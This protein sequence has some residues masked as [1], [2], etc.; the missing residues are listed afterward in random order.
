MQ[1]LE[2]AKIVNTHGLLGEVKVL[3]NY[4]G[5]HFKNWVPK[6]V[7]YLKNNSD[8]QPLTIIK[9]RTHKNFL[10]VTFEDYYKIDLVL[11]MKNKSLGIFDESVATDSESN[12]S[13]VNLI[14]YQ[15]INS[16]SNQ[17]LGTVT[18]LIENNHSGLW[19][20]DNDQG[21]TFYVPNNQFFIVKID[22]IKKKVYFNL[23]SGMFNYE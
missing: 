14:D 6:Q 18:A 8:Y 7:V 10:L 5:K 17:V 16:D 22:K 15:V 11:F 9:V 2:I 13:F 21:E 4:Y 3:C 1:Y 19:Q 20:V 12:F 23:I